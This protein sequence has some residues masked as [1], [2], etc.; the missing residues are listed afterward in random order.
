MERILV[1]SLVD[2][3]VQQLKLSLSLSIYSHYLHYI[4]IY[5]S[6]CSFSC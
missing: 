6:V 5:I 1:F 4:D 3:I 2:I